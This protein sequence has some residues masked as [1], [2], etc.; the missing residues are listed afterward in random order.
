MGFIGS[1]ARWTLLIFIVVAFV[2]ALSFAIASAFII[3]REDQSVQTDEAESAAAGTQPMVTA[4][5][6]TTAPETSAT[7]PLDPTSSTTPTTTPPTAAAPSAI[8]AI[9]PQVETSIG[10][11]ACSRPDDPNTSDDPYVLTITETASDPEPLI[12]AVDLAL[13]DGRRERRTVE[14][15]G[16]SAVEIAV[17]QSVG[18]GYVGCSIVALQQG[19]QVVRF[20]G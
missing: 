11:V 2:I 15:A 6:A 20:A 9:P 8:D 16:G 19:D 1:L 7:Q 10:S 5:V 4:E 12:V 18:A 14:A 17:P 3:P 13:G